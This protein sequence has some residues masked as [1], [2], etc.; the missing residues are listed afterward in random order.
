MTQKTTPE[1]HSTP[2][3]STTFDKDILPSLTQSIHLEESK[4]PYRSQVGIFTITLIVSLVLAWMLITPIEEVAIA[5][6]QV[7]P[8]DFIKTVQHL[9]GGIINEIHVNE[10][11]IIKENQLLIRLDEKA[12]TSELDTL[13]IREKTLQIKAERL[14]AIGLNT[15]PDFAKFG[16]ELKNIIEDQKAIYEMQLKNRQD[17]RTIIEKQLEQRK[18][19]LVI[20][21][22]QE[23]DYREQL[24]VVQQ[25]RDVNKEL[26]E[27]RLLTG[28]EYRRSEENV[29]KVRKDLN[30]V[31]NQTQETRQLIAEEETRLLELETRLRNEALTEMG[32]VTA[33]LAQV[34]E[35]KAKLEDRVHRLEIKSPISGIVK[36]IKNH[37]IGGVVQP[38]AE[39]MQ[40]VPV[41]ALEIEAQIKPQDMGNVKVGLPVVVKVSAYEFSR[42]GSIKGKL[43]SISAS[44]FM[45]D[46]NQPFYKVF[47]SVDQAYVGKD[48]EINRI[49][50]GMT[51]QADIKTGEKTLFQYLIKPV[52]NAWYS[53]FREK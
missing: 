26:F 2:Q 21:L 32:N 39:I 16:N 36:G 42:F 15:Q 47:I 38:G 49:T 12:A 51:V 8:T 46:K 53:S 35:A 50:P 41:D 24:E 33:E 34:T 48:P 25:Q 30:Q 43:R 19:Q 31:M 5:Q 27:K 28:T 29:M 17:Q 7:I 45:D 11:D 9:E 10:G 20:Q 18:A 37:T 22:G 52:Y 6:G 13:R 23:R 44:T 3:I 14:R 40:I 1:Q 4:P